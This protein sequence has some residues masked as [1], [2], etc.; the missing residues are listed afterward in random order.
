MSVKIDLPEPKLL[1]IRKYPDPMLKTVCET[2][3]EVTPEIKALVQ[4]MFI[5]MYKSEGVGLSA[6][7]VGVPLRIFVMDTSNSGQKR[8]VFINP[9]IVEIN[10]DV[11]RYREGCLSF[12]NVFAYVNRRKTLYVKALN[13]NGEV[14]ERQLEGIDAICFQHEYDHLDGITFYDHL[15][16]LQK[17]MIRKKMSKIK[18]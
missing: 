3:E 2:V 1:E 13:E 15:S 12:P 17:N 9:V 14:F 11:E 6:N 18:K 5:T 10:D 4:N 7:Q 16:P 8:A